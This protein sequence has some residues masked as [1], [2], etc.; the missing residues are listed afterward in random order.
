MAAFCEQPACLWKCS[1]L[2]Y[3]LQSECCCNCLRLLTRD[4]C[5]IWFTYAN[6][7]KYLLADLVCWFICHKLCWLCRQK[8][9][10]VLKWSHCTWI[11]Y[12]VWIC[13]E[14]TCCV[15]EQYITVRSFWHSMSEQGQDENTQ[16]RD[17]TTTSIDL[18]GFFS[19]FVC[20]FHV[21]VIRREIIL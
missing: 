4:W 2:V 19:P 20:C 16:Q 5:G 1:W 3:Q 6:G 9:W 21:A 15:E 11:Q 14:N 8:Q 12:V 13:R 18:K 10:T 17:D 7:N